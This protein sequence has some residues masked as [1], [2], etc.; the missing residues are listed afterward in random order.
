MA[1]A[2]AD[3]IT[4]MAVTVVMAVRVATEATERVAMTVLI[5]RAPINKRK[6]SDICVKKNFSFPTAYEW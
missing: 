4:V 2:T 5:T 6:R 3:M 1:A